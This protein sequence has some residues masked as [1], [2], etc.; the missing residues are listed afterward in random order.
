[1]ISPHRQ[2][3]LF[4]N[5][6][7]LNVLDIGNGPIY[8]LLHGGAGPQSMQGLA[9]ALS[10]NGRVLLPTHPGFAGQPRPDWFHRPQDLVLAYLAL[11]D[12]LDAQK[13][14][15]VGNS[16]GGWLAAEMALRRSDRIAAIALLNAVG[17]DTGSVE[18][19]IADPAR[20]SPGEVAAM[21]FHN[22]AQYA[23]TPA[24]PEAAAAMAAN[25]KALRVYAGS[26][27]MHDPTLHDRLALMSVPAKVIWGESDRIVDVDYGRRFADAMPGAEF[28]TIA[29]AGHLIRRSMI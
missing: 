27:F 26:T 20:F 9:E 15:I 7:R 18:K 5:T 6:L 25:Q 29:Q 13:V 21:A 12:E 2:L 17:I 8:L 11:L 28:I 22:P 10:V 4:G 1:M 23:L 14:M 16:F 24:S 3:N 19:T